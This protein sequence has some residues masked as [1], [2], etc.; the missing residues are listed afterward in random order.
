MLRINV[1]PLEVALRLVVERRDE[2]VPVVHKRGFHRQAHYIEK[3]SENR[4]EHDQ[5]P[6]GS[7]QSVP[8]GSGPG[9]GLPGGWNCCLHALSGLGKRDFA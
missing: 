7:G 8:C 5:N 6:D 1:A 3:G 4:Q 2:H 9:T